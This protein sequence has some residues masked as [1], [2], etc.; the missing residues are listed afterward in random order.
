M[1]RVHMY[2]CTKCPG[3]YDHTVLLGTGFAV[4]TIIFLILSL[5]SRPHSRHTSSVIINKLSFSQPCPSRPLRCVCVYVHTC[6]CVCDA[7]IIVKHPILLPFVVD[8]CY[9]PLLLW[10]FKCSWILGLIKS[11]TIAW[12]FSTVSSLYPALFSG[13]MHFI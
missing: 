3:T 12:Q 2:V 5:L 8:Q 13:L 10:L 6:M 9:S 11:L 7:G 1:L 4:T